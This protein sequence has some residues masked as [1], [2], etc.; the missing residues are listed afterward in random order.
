MKS[1]M[2]GQQICHFHGGKNPNALR[3][4]QERLL[5]LAEPAIEGLNRALESNDMP[6]IVSAARVVLDR[7][8]LG[9]H[10]TVTLQR[11]TDVD[12]QLGGLS[13]EELIVEAEENLASLR[14]L[15]AQQQQRQLEPM[16][17]DGEAVVER[18]SR[19]APLVAD[20]EV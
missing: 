16:V 10:A 3:K 15:Q 6:A 20:E 4:A 9:P 8:G 1:A 19:D 13:L 17:I 14:E 12:D 11:G 2:R 5:A 7:V 18:E